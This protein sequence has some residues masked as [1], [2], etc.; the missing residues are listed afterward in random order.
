MDAAFTT[1]RLAEINFYQYGG[2]PFIEQGQSA[3]LYLP[4]YLCVTLAK[5]V[6]GSA[7]WTIEWM[8]GTAFN[9][10][11]RSVLYSLLRSW[12]IEPLIAA[13]GGLLWILCP[14]VLI[15][16]S[17]WEAVVYIVCY[18][19]WILLATDRLLKEPNFKSGCFL[20]FPVG[21]FLLT[22]AVQFLAYVLLFAGI[23]GYFGFRELSRDIQ[24]RALFYALLAA[25][26]DFIVVIPVLLPLMH[27]SQ[28]SAHR[29]SAMPPPR[30]PSPI[31]RF[32]GISADA[33]FRVWN[34][35]AQ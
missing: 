14:F 26:L 21:L 2:S 17:N 6:S 35:V 13:F 5:Y 16:S 1:G 34:K 4:S 30:R 29:G 18:M 12:R 33:I 9:R 10:G 24:A 27:D 11:A 23:Y 31:S 28:I 3:V 25:V 20:A 19:P 7:L 32:E 15:L 8:M 22:G